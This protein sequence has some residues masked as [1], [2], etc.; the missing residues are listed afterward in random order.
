MYLNMFFFQ[1]INW[2]LIIL[3]QSKYLI[4]PPFII[5]A[6]IDRH[7]DSAKTTSW[8]KY[9]WIGDNLKLEKWTWNGDSYEKNEDKMTF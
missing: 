4:W 9:F 1:N 5:E 7:E 6:T 2:Y 3:H 8:R